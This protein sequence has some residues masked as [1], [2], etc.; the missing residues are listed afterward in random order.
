MSDV[1]ALEY[2]ALYCSDVCISSTH[3]ALRVIITSCAPALYQRVLATAWESCHWVAGSG[4]YLGCRDWG[5]LTVIA[6]FTWYP[7]GQEEGV[8]QMALPVPPGTDVVWTW[9]LRIV[10]ISGVWLLARRLPGADLSMAN[11]WS[12]S[13]IRAF[14]STSLPYS[15][16]DCLA[17]TLALYLKIGPAPLEW[18][19]EVIVC[20]YKLSSCRATGVKWWRWH[21]RLSAGQE[22]LEASP[23]NTSFECQ[24]CLTWSEVQP[25]RILD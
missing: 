12:S 21:W 25:F 7:G 13:S 22:R 4:R 9:I 19:D 6:I 8:E 18:K 24:A 16:F 15:H 1:C 11:V 14:L 23:W 2:G 3:L 10:I 5:M 20:T 17:D